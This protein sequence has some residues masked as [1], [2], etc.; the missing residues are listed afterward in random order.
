M[1][2]SPVRSA[3]AKETRTREL[4][5]RMGGA[6]PHRPLPQRLEAGSDGGLVREA[7]GGD[8]VLD[9]QKGPPLRG[10]LPAMGGHGQGG[11]AR[12]EG[13]VSAP[14]PLEEARAL[15]VLLRT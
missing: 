5:H 12:S 15:L 11:Q 13:I 4:H 8:E 9:A 2:H 7:V 1:A 14:T 6:I 10:E 3:S